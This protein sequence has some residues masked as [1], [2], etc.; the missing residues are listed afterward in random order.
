[1]RHVAEGSI[2]PGDIAVNFVR[3]TKPAK[4]V[5]RLDIDKDGI[6]TKPWPGG[7]FEERLNEALDFARAPLKRARELAKGV[8][9]DA[10]VMKGF[11]FNYIREEVCPARSLVEKIELTT[12]SQ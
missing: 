2:S 4:Q 7:F 1:M 5:T 10:N 6:F 11:T 8:A 9:V 12:V 3:A